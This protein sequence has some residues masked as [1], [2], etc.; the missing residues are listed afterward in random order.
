MISRL[1]FYLIII[2]ICTVCL[3]WP[4]QGWLLLRSIRESW[5]SKPCP[6][7]LRT[8]H[9]VTSAPSTCWIS[10]PASI[11][12]ERSIEVNPGQ[13]Y[14]LNLL[15]GG[16]TSL[17]CRACRERAAFARRPPLP[18]RLQSPLKTSSQK[19]QNRN[20]L[21]SISFLSACATARLAES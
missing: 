11:N 6:R 8:R 19:Y 10:S 16:T 9:C 18:S 7:F 4:Q 5:P 1:N 14:P 12:Q 21:N 17:I 20:I 15:S 2:C 13:L 3:A